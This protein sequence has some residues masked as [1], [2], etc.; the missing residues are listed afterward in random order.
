M[1]PMSH[2]PPSAPYLRPIQFPISHVIG[3]TH[4]SH[5]YINLIKR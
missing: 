1:S 5:G 4:E 2:V 3:L